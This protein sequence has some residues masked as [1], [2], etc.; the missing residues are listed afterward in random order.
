MEEIEYLKNQITALIV[1][2]SQEKE[3][4]IA[5]AIEKTEDTLERKR[6]QWNNERTKERKDI[7]ARAKIEAEVAL[8][9]AKKEIAFT[10]TRTAKSE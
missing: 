9:R 7:I 5:M 6:V 4:A 2:K 3:D 8:T 10:S 1:E